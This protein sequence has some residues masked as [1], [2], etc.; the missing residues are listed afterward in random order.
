MKKSKNYIKTVTLPTIGICVLLGIIFAIAIGGSKPKEPATAEQVWDIMVSHGYQPY[1]VTYQND[2]LDSSN[3]KCIAF[4]KDDLQFEFYVFN[5]KKRAVNAYG[6][7]Y[8]D[9]ILNKN[10]IAKAEHKTKAANY[11]IYTLKVSGTYYV[12]IYVGNTAVY[13]YCNEENAHE[14]GDI[15]TEIGY[16]S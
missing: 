9:F 7:F 14:I 13:A 1:D 6:V 11:A 3:E 8:T 2:T 10:H 4:K 5:S 15:L 16:F 12:A